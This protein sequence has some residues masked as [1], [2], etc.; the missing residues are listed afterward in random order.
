MAKK[1]P[2]MLSQTAPNHCATKLRVVADANRLS[3][4]TL[5]SE[6]GPLHVFEMIETLGLEQTLLSHH[7]RILREEGFLNSERRGKKV[8]YSLMDGVYP[9]KNGRREIDLGCCQLTFS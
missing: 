6:K 4:L 7:L 9:R 3:I 5:L 1:Q 8:L 2:K